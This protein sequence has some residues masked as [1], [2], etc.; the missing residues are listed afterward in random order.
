[1]V[2]KKIFVGLFFLFSFSALAEVGTV[3]DSLPPTPQKTLS[4]TASLETPTHT[5]LISTDAG[6]VDQRQ[7][8]Q[9]IQYNP[10][11]GPNVGIH[12]SYEQ[13]GFGLTKRFYLGS[14]TDE[15]KYGKTDY[16]DYRVDYTFSDYVSIDAYLQNYH[17]F[18]TDLSGQEGLQTTFDSNGNSVQT[19]GES[20]IIKRSDIVTRNYGLRAQF[21]LPLMPLFSRFDKKAADTNLEFNLL[22]KIYYNH[23]EIIGDQTLVPA[24]TSN[25]FSPISSLKEIS[26]NTLGVGLGL[27]FT[28]HTTAESS[29]GFSALAGPGFQRQTNIYVDRGETLYTTATELNAELHYNWKNTLHEFQTGLYF[30]TIRS[31]VK[32]IN[33]D[34]SNLGIK[35][36]YSYSGFQL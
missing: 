1:M 27:G 36:A 31:N 9:R 13:W 4:L 11:F 32:D 2:S 25:A 14:P 30:D 3:T 23:L 24:A 16:D 28:V 8:D 20:H 29:F 6:R 12:G 5:F 18:Y 33:F 26:A 22:S 19:T 7:V 35:V 34:S 15:Q 17:G 21:A 10:T